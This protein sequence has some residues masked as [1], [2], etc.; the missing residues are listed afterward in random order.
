MHRAKSCVHSLSA[1]PPKTFNLSSKSLEHEAEPTFAFYECAIPEVEDWLL[2][3]SDDKLVRIWDTSSGDM[4]ADFRGHAAGPVSVP[5]SPLDR[6]KL[7]LA[8]VCPSQRG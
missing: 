6:P 5:M 3:C 1:G 8:V 4:L 2:S 7:G